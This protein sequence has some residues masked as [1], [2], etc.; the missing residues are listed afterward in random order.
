M[1]TDYP[2]PPIIT[3]PAP[4]TGQVPLWNGTEWIA[5]TP[6]GATGATGGTGASGPTG[7]TGPT[8]A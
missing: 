4:L 7:P 6:S 3:G 2:N 1:T 5:A 8:G